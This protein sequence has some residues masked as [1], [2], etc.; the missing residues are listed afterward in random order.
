[1]KKNKNILEVCLSPDL[2][3]LE[4]YMQTCAK[5][6]SSDFNLLSVINTKSKLKS[7]FENTS[8]KHIEQIGRASCRERV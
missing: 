2:G 3:G 4:L 1:M 7:Y 6:L 8:H 5:E